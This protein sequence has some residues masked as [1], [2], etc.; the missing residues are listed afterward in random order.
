MAQEI[1]RASDWVSSSNALISTVAV[2]DINGATG[3]GAW[4]G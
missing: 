1:G 2:V 3:I 4:F